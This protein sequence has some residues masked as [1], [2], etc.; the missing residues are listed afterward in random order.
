MAEDGLHPLFWENTP[1]DWS[2]YPDYAS[3]MMLDE[4]GSPEEAVEADKI[5]GN[6]AL[7]RK[8]VNAYIEAM[9]YYNVAISRGVDNPKINSVLFA[10]R[11][12]VNM[13]WG[14]SFIFNSS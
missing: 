11:A 12:A 2:Q 1:D 5:R 3:L 6:N 13:I 9:K 4:D 14:I 7:K 8:N 10:N